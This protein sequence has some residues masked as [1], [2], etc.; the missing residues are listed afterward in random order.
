MEQRSKTLYSHSVSP[1]TSTGKVSV[2]VGKENSL[3]SSDPFLQSGQK[4]EFRADR[5]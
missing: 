1:M 3:N 4:G 2:P 5:R